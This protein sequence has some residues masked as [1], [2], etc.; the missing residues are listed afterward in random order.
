MGLFGSICLSTLSPA[1]LDHDTA[2]RAAYEAAQRLVRER[3]YKVSRQFYED[4][5]K[6]RD[7]SRDVFV[8]MLFQELGWPPLP[9]PANMVG[10][11]GGRASRGSGE[12]VS[13]LD[14]CQEGREKGWR[15]AG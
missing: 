9:P 13:E 1:G 8:P 10:R 5:A 6:S 12:W 2:V 7:F 3:G 11:P 15:G 14:S 4:H